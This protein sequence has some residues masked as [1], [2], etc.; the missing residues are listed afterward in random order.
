M[1]VRHAA[2]ADQF[3]PGKP[4]RLKIVIDSY[5][6][7]AKQLDFASI[8]GIMVP[9]AGYVFSGQTAAAAYKQLQ[10]RMYKAIV[11]LAPSHSMHIDGVSAYGGD[12][13][14]TPLGAVPVDV[15]AVRRLEQR[16]V[17][18]H[19]SDSGHESL[20]DRAEHSL[21]VQ[22]PFLQI[23]LPD[24]KIVPLV[25]HDYSWDNCRQLGDAIA[26]TFDSKK[27][28]ILASTDLYHGQSY[29]ECQQSDAATLDSL[30]NDSPIQFCFNANNHKIMACGAGPVTALKVVAEKWG[31]HQPK[32]IAHTN[33]ADVTGN[34][35][36]YV[37]GYA[38]AVAAKDEL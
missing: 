15:E 26:E 36:G 34:K 9:H 25:F 14:E 32:V 16:A 28:L 31:A 1:Q 37:V 11:I 12:F 33:S 10:G 6:D 38:A 21:E 27:T 30:E 5:L 17:N 20:T 35:H 4:D 8:I 19:V 24:V 7:Q 23:V 29:E 13:Y 22:L 3:Y 2:W 18:V